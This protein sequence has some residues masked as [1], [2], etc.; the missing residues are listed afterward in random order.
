MKGKKSLLSNEMRKVRGGKDGSRG[1]LK[2]TTSDF[3]FP[4][5]GRLMR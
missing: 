5:G 3:V 2:R 4:R 1:V